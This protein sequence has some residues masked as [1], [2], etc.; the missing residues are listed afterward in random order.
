MLRF[1]ARVFGL[2]DP[3]NSVERSNKSFLSTIDFLLLA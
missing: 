1:F 3:L 2:N